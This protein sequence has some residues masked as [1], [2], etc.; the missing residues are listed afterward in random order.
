MFA[1][2]SASWVCDFMVCM[3]TVPALRQMSVA[4]SENYLGTLTETKYL[5]FCVAATTMMRRSMGWVARAAK[6]TPSRGL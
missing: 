4:L 2:A 5:E 3:A 1:V 6:K